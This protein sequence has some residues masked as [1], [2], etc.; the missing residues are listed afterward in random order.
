MQRQRGAE[1][2]D[3]VGFGIE[4]EVGL[5][6]AGAQHHV[7]A[8][9]AL[10]GHIGAHDAVAALGHDRH[11]LAP[12][13]GIETGAEE[14]EVQ[15]VRDLL[16]LHQVLAGFRTD[17]VDGLQRRARQLELAARLQTDRGGEALG[18]FALQG[19]DVAGFL[20]RRPAKALQAGQHGQDAVLALIGGATQGGLV[21][22]E[23]LVFGADAPLVGR[24]LALRHGV[25]QLLFRKR[26]R[27]GHL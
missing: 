18:V 20:H 11:V 6:G 2:H 12:P 23:L 8:Q 15:L 13:Q 16:V 26:R 7:E 21:E 5:D 3:H 14:A 1:L 27:V 25:D 19:D 24:L 17:V 10:L 4:V 9:R 22:A